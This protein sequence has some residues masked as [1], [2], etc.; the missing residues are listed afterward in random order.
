MP[1]ITRKQLEDYHKL[2]NDRIHGRLLTPEGLRLICEVNKYDPES[3]GKQL[4]ET[5]AKL[6]SEGRYEKL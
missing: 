1:T 5:Y 3:I 6:K 4:L 2:C